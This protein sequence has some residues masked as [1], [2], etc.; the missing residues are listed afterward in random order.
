M[1]IGFIAL[2][3]N[4][5]QSL[6]LWRGAPVRKAGGMSVYMFRTPR[7]PFERVLNLKQE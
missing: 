6:L 3:L 1:S 5:S 2:S 4:P 7:H